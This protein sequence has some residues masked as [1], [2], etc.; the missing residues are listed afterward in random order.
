[1]DGPTWW[2]P[3]AAMALV[4]VVML[5]FGLLPLP[6]MPRVAA[7]LCTTT[8]GL[9]VALYGIRFGNPN[10]RMASILA[11]VLLIGLSIGLLGT[12]VN[13]P[14]SGGISVETAAY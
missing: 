11:A 9:F 1:M 10:Q 8:V 12:V 4:P 13:L 2:H 3:W 6:E 5:T 7:G 14:L